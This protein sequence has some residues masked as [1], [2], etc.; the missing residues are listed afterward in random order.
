LK[1]SKSRHGNISTM[2]GRSQKKQ[3]ENDKRKHFKAAR[4]LLGLAL[5]MGRAMI[6]IRYKN[7]SFDKPPGHQ[8]RAKSDPYEFQMCN[9]SS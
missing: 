2:P 4:S 7:W 6:L 8:G 3:G 9:H 1:I 5:A